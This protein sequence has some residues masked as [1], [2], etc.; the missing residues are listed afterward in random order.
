MR[1][2][3]RLE[4][5]DVK[6][7][8]TSAEAEARKIGVDMDIAVVD[9]GGNLLGFVRMDRA[10]VTGI[11]ISID[12]A[13]T[14]A[15]TRRKTADYKPVGSPE[16]MAFGIHSSH[17]GRFTIYGGGVPIVIDGECAGGVGCSSG[18]PEQDEQVAQAGIN[19]LLQNKQ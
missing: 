19:A 9:D 11:Q 13:F 10:K 8:L 2:I 3:P 16:G 18:S 15:C 6:I 14:A 12:K 17:N 7:I 5:E 1:K 4:Q